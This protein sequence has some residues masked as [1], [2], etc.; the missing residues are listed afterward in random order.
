MKLTGSKTH[1]FRVTND[2][3]LVKSISQL[4]S[5]TPTRRRMTKNKNKQRNKKTDSWKVFELHANSI[6]EYIGT[7][8]VNLSKIAY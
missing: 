6:Y 3:T 1:A 4:V 5:E 8:R 2:E 7:S